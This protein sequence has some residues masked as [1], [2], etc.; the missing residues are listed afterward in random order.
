[1]LGTGPVRPW[2]FR[3]T[4]P[5]TRCTMT[6]PVPPAPAYCRLTVLAPRA[7]VDVALPADVPVADLVPMVLELVGEP[8]PG[9][10]PRPWRL[11]GAAGGTFPAGAT[12]SQLG[13]LDGELLRIAPAGTTPT[14]P[15]FDDPVDALAATA[16]PAAAT[17]RRWGAAAV[18]VLAVAAGVL[19]ALG[20]MVGVLVAAPAA[21]AAVVV[22]ARSAAA[23]DR[24]ADRPPADRPA[25][26]RPPT[27]PPV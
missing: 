24:P 14:P 15:T 21:I 1:M 22:A 27:D 5:S 17:R 3:R 20:E 25:P 9:Q 26:G 7:S 23:A 11:S 19:L 2:P 6:R 10:P 13:V 16:D 4:R 8:A 12:L 18:L